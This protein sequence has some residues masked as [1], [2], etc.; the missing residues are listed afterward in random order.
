MP[1]AAQ[2]W[3]W[4]SFVDPDRPEGD[5]FVGACIVQGDD[6]LIGG[7][8][9]GT[10]P[11]SSAWRLG[12]NP[13]GEVQLVRVPDGKVDA[14]PIEYREVLLTREQVAELDQLLAP[15]G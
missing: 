13:G 5:R 8:L 7:R 10:D 4:L 1:D 2:P 3:W 11:V 12:I 9:A 6:D 14:V 15:N